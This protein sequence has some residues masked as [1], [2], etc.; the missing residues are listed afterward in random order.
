MKSF[1]GRGNQHRR[2]SLAQP[3]TL[4]AKPD[5]SSAGTRGTCGTK[6]TLQFGTK[7]FRGTRDTRNVITNV[8]YDW[9]TGLEGKHS[10]ERR[11]AIN[12]RGSNVQAQRDIVESA[13]ANRPDA[14]LDRMEDR[15]KT[16]PAGGVAVEN[17]A[18]V[19]DWPC[20]VLPLAALPTRS[21]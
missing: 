4:A 6:R 2:S 5:R 12:F 19:A 7:V 18:R 15:Q 10:I 16:M 14:V 20:N 11:Y 17:S 9:R 3:Q 21:E 1:S 13:G 8:G